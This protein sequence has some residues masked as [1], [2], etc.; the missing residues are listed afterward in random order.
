M[1]II[2]SHQELVESDAL[3]SVA[4]IPLAKQEIPPTETPFPSRRKKCHQ[5]KKRRLQEENHLSNKSD[6]K[7]IK[8]KEAQQQKGQ[9]RAAEELLD[10]QVFDPCHRLTPARK[11]AK[12]AVAEIDRDPRF[13]KM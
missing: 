3:K 5:Q 12:L 13:R 6:M 8:K 9:K 1:V 2:L 7:R 10:D 11:L 4:Q